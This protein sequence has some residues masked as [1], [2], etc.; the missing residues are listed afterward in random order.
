MPEGKNKI[1]KQDILRK[2]EAMLKE[3]INLDAKLI[4]AKLEKFLGSDDKVYNFTS[5]GIGY[6]Q[7]DEKRQAEYLEWEKGIKQE[8]FAIIE[9]IRD[10][11]KKTK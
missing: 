10:S 9:E 4:F 11:I 7:I 3:N 2:I 5:G 8:W 1:T 6:V